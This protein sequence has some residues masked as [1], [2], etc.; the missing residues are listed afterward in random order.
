MY[1]YIYI[2]RY[3]IYIYI[4]SY[5]RKGSKVLQKTLQLR[6]SDAGFDHAAVVKPAELKR[7]CRLLGGQFVLRGICATDAVVLLVMLMMMVMMIMRMM[8]TMV[9]MTMAGKMMF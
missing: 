8:M 9:T 5:Y 4:I 6:T 2:D 1:I 7:W 3:Y